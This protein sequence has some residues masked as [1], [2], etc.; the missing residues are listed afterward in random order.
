MLVNEL[1]FEFVCTADIYLNN[2]FLLCVWFALPGP[3]SIVDQGHNYCTDEPSI[4]FL[5]MEV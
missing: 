3:R 1:V 2:M 5:H 4:D